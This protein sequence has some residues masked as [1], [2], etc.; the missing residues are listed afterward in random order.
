MKSDTYNKLVTQAGILR[1]TLRD[2]VQVIENVHN[3]EA[4]NFD[5]YDELAAARNYLSG[6][7]E[8]V[9]RFVITNDLV[10]NVDDEPLAESDEDEDV[11]VHTETHVT[12]PENGNDKSN[13]HSDTP[14]PDSV[15]IAT[16]NHG[17]VQGVDF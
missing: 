17:F 4:L 2:S 11:A 3:N 16:H 1:Q 10:N 5:E 8:E 9:D 13:T 14:E 6:V 7:I 12:A 15:F